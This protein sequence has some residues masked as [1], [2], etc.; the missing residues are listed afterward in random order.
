MARPL[1]DYARIAPLFSQWVFNNLP[2]VFFVFF[3]SLIYIFNAN[4]SNRQVKRI[5]IAER[6]IKD[7]QWKYNKIKSDVMLNTKQSDVEKQVEVLGL[8]SSNQRTKRIIVKN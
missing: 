3:L 1:K 2:F 4:F 5:Q 8:H 7:L 6:E